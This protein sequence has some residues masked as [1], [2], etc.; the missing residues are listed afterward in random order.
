MN[1]VRT[2]LFEGLDAEDTAKLTVLGRLLT[3]APGEAL[4]ALGEEAR[5]VFIVERGRV[6]LFMTMRVGSRDEAVPIEE[7]Q[8]GQ[9]VGWS[10]LIPPHKYTLSARAQAQSE[11]LAIPR[12]PL[13]DYLNEH[14][15]VGHVVH[16]NLAAIVG[17]RLQVLEAMWLREMQRTVAHHYA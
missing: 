10:A 6:A 13:V 2:E 4:F 14:P 5:E 11:L 17:H 15:R 16:R 3:L 1:R 8:P 12:G 7:R 9:I